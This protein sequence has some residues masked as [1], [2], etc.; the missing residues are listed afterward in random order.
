MTVPCY[1]DG[2]YFVPVPG[3][4]VDAED[5]ESD[6]PGGAP[7]I[8]EDFFSPSYRHSRRTSSRSQ[9]GSEEIGIW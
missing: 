4:L 9:S 7:V 3:G 8:I 2:E 6:V 1:V 5:E